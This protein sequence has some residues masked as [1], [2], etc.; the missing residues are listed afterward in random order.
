MTV[1]GC[2]TLHLISTAAVEITWQAVCVSERPLRR[3]VSPEPPIKH[4]DKYVFLSAVSSLGKWARTHRHADTH[5]WKKEN[6]RFLKISHPAKKKSALERRHQRLV[7]SVMWQLSFLATSFLTPLLL[8]SPN[9]SRSIHLAAQNCHSQQSVKTQHS[10]SPDTGKMYLFIFL[11][12]IE[13]RKTLR[14]SQH[15]FW[16]SVCVYW[17]FFPPPFL[18]RGARRRDTVDRDPGHSWQDRTLISV[19]AVSLRKLPGDVCVQT[20]LDPH[21]T[22]SESP[23]CSFS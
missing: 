13:K 18:C 19:V 10:R 9:V 20:E 1:I 22:L 17:P 15:C 14:F 2:A 23:T 12:D 6:N 16:F 3:C 4:V 8:S 21:C 7:A 5:T 11:P